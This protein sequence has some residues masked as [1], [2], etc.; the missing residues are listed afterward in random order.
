[1]KTVTIEYFAVL[2]EHTGV[3]SEQRRTA[4]ATPALLY[5]EL[6]AHYAFPQLQ[7]VK[8]AINDEF[9]SMDA[10]LGDGDAVVFIPPV[11]GG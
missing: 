8:V 9:S 6:A 4:A 3:A 7:S 10:P 1:M 5:A 2:R 11:A